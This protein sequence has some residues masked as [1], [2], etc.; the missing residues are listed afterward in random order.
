[1]ASRQAVGPTE[2]ALRTLWDR[3]KSPT[4]RLLS[5]GFLRELQLRR[6]F[7]TTFLRE[8]DVS[9]EVTQGA[10]PDCRRCP[11]NC[12]RGYGSVVSLRLCDVARLMDLGRTDLM[13]KGKPRF[14]RSFLEERPSLRPVMESSLWRSLPVLHQTGPERRCAALTS[15]LRCSLHPHWPWS[16]A[17]FPY[18]LAADNRRIVWG[19]R[20]PV[21]KRQPDPERAQEL[22]SAVLSAYNQRIRDAVLLAH[23]RPQLIELGM[24]S[25]LTAENEDPFER[26]PEKVGP[27]RVNG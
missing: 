24:G 14:P 26:E 8:V 12:C 11:N 1:M 4:A 19:S 7:R 13:R 6:R 21:Q 16:C 2:S 22:A 27:S 25:W 15:E 20:C 5:S 9:E 10:V 17:R 3:F 18:T 23:A